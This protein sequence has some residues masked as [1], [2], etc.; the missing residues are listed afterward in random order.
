MESNALRSSLHTPS[1]IRSVQ[2]KLTSPL[3]SFSQNEQKNSSKGTLMVSLVFNLDAFKLSVL[4]G[5]VLCVLRGWQCHNS[6]FQPL[7][8]C[9]RRRIGGMGV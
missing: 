6:G 5:E 2:A 7:P 1:S 8:S 4:C 9:C 3:I